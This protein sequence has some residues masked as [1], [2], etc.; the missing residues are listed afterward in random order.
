MESRS[1][2]CLTKGS[3]DRNV[4][5][6]HY[7]T[8]Q[9]NKNE[10]KQH[11]KSSDGIRKAR[12]LSDISETHNFDF[13]PNDGGTHVSSARKLHVSKITKRSCMSQQQ[14]MCK[15]KKTR[16]QSAKHREE[17]QRDCA[18]AT[19][20]ECRI[21][22]KI[23]SCRKKKKAS[24]VAHTKKTCCGVREHARACRPVRARVRYNIRTVSNHQDIVKLIS[25]L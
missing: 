9:T 15:Q 22:L 2:R 25:N 8:T 18:H 19:S 1:E 13:A 12:K 16:S 6:A 11:E 24:F 7:Q 20:E 4:R 5:Q 23:I 3:C 10:T 21:E 14:R 17:K